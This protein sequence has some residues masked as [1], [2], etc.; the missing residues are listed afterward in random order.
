MKPTEY[1]R[2][3]LNVAT[4][5]CAALTVITIVIYL[6]IQ[7]NACSYKNNVVAEYVS[8]VTCTCATSVGT[9]NQYSLAMVTNSSFGRQMDSFIVTNPTASRFTFHGYTIDAFGLNVYLQSYFK[10]EF[11]TNLVHS[12]ALNVFELYNPQNFS[13]ASMLQYSDFG[14]AYSCIIFGVTNGTLYSSDACVA[15]IAELTGATFN[16][17][18]ELGYDYNPV[19]QNFCQVQSCV[20]QTCSGSDAWAILLQ[21]SGLIGALM[22]VNRLVRFGLI[23]VLPL[24]GNGDG[25][26]EMV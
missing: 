4:G 18:V 16:P 8:N 22:L 17:V 15:K 9:F 12:K 25:A 26:G 11:T 23:R 20:I 7:Y 14:I 2:R 21:A 5:A 13:E 1:Q 19:Y 6:G 10:A 3:Y 24:K